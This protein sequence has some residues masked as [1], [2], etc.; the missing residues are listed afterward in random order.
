MFSKSI[1]LIIR[2]GQLLCS[3]AIMAL[4]GNMLSTSY[5]NQIPQPDSA[6]DNAPEVKFT[7]F[8]SVFSLISLFFLGPA[9]WKYF[10]NHKV[11]IFASALDALNL[12][13]YMSDGI[14]LAAALKVHSCDNPTY[15]KSNPIT[16]ASPNTKVRCREAQAATAFVWFG[17]ILFTITTAFSLSMS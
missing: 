4:I 2:L 9:S 11:F 17:F 15:T 10:T 14:A 16:Q 13:F 6:T 3:T 5:W 1:A 12:I 7:M 8:I